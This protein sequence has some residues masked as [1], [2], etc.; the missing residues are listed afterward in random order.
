MK[1]F[2]KIF[3]KPT[4]EDN[5]KAID[6]LHNQMIEVLEFRYKEPNKI[7]LEM[8]AHQKQVK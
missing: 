6:T 5:Q 8:Y 3:S 1:W 2:L 7:I 4:I